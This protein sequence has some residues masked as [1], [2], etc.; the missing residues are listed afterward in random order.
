MVVGGAAR[1]VGLEAEFLVVVVS[2][3]MLKFKYLLDGFNFVSDRSILNLT[4]DYSFFRL[5]FMLTVNVEQLSQKRSP[6]T[7]K[8]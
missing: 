1:S 5:V 3:Q 2:V 6:N 7:E 4:I 8:F